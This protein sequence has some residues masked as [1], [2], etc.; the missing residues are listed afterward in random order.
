MAC[1]FMEIYCGPSMILGKPYQ[2]KPDNVWK[3]SR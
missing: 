2:T 3:P 1:K